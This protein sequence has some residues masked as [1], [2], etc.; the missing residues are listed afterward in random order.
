MIVLIILALL[1]A[2]GVI[3]FFQIKVKEIEEKHD[4]EM[5]QLN[6]NL[7][8]KDKTITDYENTITEK[9]NKIQE[10]DDE[11]SV[12]N[13]KL[14]KCKDELSD[15]IV[16]KNN[17]IDNLNIQIKVK[18]NLLIKETKKN[19]KLEKTVQSR[20]KQLEKEKKEYENIIEEKNRELERANKKIIWL[21]NNQKAPTKEE[22]IAYDFQYKEVERR[23]KNKRRSK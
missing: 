13:I 15:T 23:N 12:L 22:I 21:S 5:D 10:K 16:K 9:K 1:F 3:L 6:D 18:D 17:D 7:D 19:Q 11:I 4:K 8:A 20:D 14:K 2:A